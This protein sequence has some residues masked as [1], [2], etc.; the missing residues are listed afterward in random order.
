MLRSGRKNASCTVEDIAGGSSRITL[1][2]SAITVNSTGSPVWVS[3]EISS[4]GFTRR[5][6]PRGKNQEN[7]NHFHEQGQQPLT[8]AM[9]VV[10]CIFKLA[11]R[12]NNKGNSEIIQFR[13]SDKTVGELKEITKLFSKKFAR[14]LMGPSLIW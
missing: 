2:S 5:I 1:T 8:V 10:G 14:F 3:A 12:N 9:V 4:T 7:Q 11:A 6:S 13:S